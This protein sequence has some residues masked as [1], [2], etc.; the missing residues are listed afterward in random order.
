MNG[1][2]TSSA[3]QTYFPYGN[4]RGTGSGVSSYTDKQFTGQ[5]R[6][7]EFYYMKARFYD[8]DTGLF[9]QPDSIV[10][11]PGDPQSLNRYTYVSGNP[12]IFTD[13]TG[14]F[15]G[16]GVCGQV[17]GAITST[18]GAVGD[19]VTD[20]PSLVSNLPGAESIENAM[21]WTWDTT[22]AAVQTAVSAVVQTVQ[23]VVNSRQ[24][25]QNA[26]TAAVGTAVERA[27]TVTNN[28]VAFARTPQGA[29]MLCGLGGPFGCGLTAIA[30]GDRIA[31][32]L[33]GPAESGA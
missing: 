5:Q 1:S 29:A 4:Q 32:A 31:C 6:E 30:N 25:V 27:N 3:S 18:I 17:V 20:I 9:L 24:T 21:L 10:P 16:C 11:N 12:M 19:V 33:G 15:P 23:N 8:P 14:Y 13:P 26:I 2:G 7:G 22:S 28:A